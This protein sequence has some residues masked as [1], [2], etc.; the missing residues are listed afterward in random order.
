MEWSQEQ[1]LVAAFEQMADALTR[2]ADAVDVEDNTK[3]EQ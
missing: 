3:E 1:R 2:I